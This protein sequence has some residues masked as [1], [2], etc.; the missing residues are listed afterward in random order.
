MQFHPHKHEAVPPACSTQVPECRCEL[1]GTG[2]PGCN[3]PG[4]SFCPNQ[5]SG[6]G[7]CDLGFCRCDAG[8]FG[9]DCAHAASAD[10]AAEA[11]RKL[12]PWLAEVTVDA[13]RCTATGDGCSEGMLWDAERANSAS[14][15][16]GTAAAPPLQAGSL[17]AEGLRPAPGPETDEPLF[18][19][20]GSDDGDAPEHVLPRTPPPPPPPPPQAPAEALRSGRDGRDVVEAS[21]GAWQAVEEQGSQH[22]RLAAAPQRA[23][24][25]TVAGPAART[26]RGELRQRRLSALRRSG[27]AG[28]GGA[29]GGDR[30]GAD[31]P[32]PGRRRP[33]VYVYNV[34]STYVARMLQYRQG[35][36]ARSLCRALANHAIAVV[37]H[38]QREGLPCAWCSTLHR[39]R[40]FCTLCQ[41]S[42]C[43]LLAARRSAPGCTA[44][45]AR[46]GG[47]TLSTTTGR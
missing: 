20:A 28:E 9:I 43:A 2:G 15:G 13:W 6:R 19:G 37:K 18:H 5:C 35:L 10:A 1:D 26:R 27:G 16:S 38:G 39:P 11:A 31:A 46:G 24:A 22:R 23:A 41:G 44:T 17:Q 42:A 40:P 32:R 29:A 25:P 12:P 33:L 47:L 8:W 3:H 45:C 21:A 4:E 14:G 30:A 7:R 34:P 36:S